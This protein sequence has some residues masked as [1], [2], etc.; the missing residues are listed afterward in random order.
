MFQY[1]MCHVSQCDPRTAMVTLLSRPKSTQDMTWNQGDRSSYTE[2]L[3][4]D[5]NSVL[6]LICFD[7]QKT[8]KNLQIFKCTLGAGHGQVVKPSCCDIAKETG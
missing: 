3:A 2:I 1:G 5:H 4:V 6:K 8:F 7:T